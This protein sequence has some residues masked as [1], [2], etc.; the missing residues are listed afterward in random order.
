MHYVIL[1]PDWGV[2]NQKV[3]FGYLDDTLLF[4]HRPLTYPRSNGA[5]SSS[6]T[7]A[8]RVAEH[9]AMAATHLVTVETPVHCARSTPLV[10]W[11]CI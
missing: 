11:V 4:A 6:R 1:T 2:A 10:Y 7:L 9:V 5:C 3:F 8:D